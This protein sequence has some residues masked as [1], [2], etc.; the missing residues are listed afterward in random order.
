MTSDPVER[1]LSSLDRPLSPRPEFAEG[2][3][4]RLLS[5]LESERD[6]DLPSMPD[7]EDLMLD[8][9]AL[10]PTTL[11]PAA[12]LPDVHLPAPRRGVR[13]DRVLTHVATAA[14]VIL[15]LGASVL[16]FGPGRAELGRFF[17]FDPGWPA[18]TQ[19]PTIIPALSAT[20]ATSGLEFLWESD[21]GPDPL[22]LPYGMDV[23]PA[24]NLWVSDSENDRFQIIAP[25]GAYRETW[26]ASGSGDGEF[27][28]LAEA[29]AFD[30]PYGDIAFDADGTF[31][32][33]DTGNTRIQKFAPDRTFLRLVGERGSR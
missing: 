27:D 11:V 32:V 24:G 15:T 29:S 3:L 7:T 28:F 25:D 18:Q 10:R 20:P 5:E 2:L 19:G 23:D 31:Y 33:A 16:A 1:L 21:G 26:G 17:G 12:P 14:L 13:R 4:D 30:R 8:P 9:I 22:D 6:A